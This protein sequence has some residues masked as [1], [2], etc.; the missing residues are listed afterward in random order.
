MNLWSTIDRKYHIAHFLICKFHDFIIQTN[1]VC[2][3]CETEFLIMCFLK[4]TSIVDDSLDNFPIQK[5]LTAEE[6]NF[7]ISSVARILN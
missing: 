2:S 4:F 7:K 1:T 3:Q 6:I 5:W